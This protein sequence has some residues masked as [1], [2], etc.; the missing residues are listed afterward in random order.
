MALISICMMT[1]IFQSIACTYT[2]FRCVDKKEEENKKKLVIIALLFFLISQFFMESFKSNPEITIFS[3]HIT[4]LIL[5]SILYRKN[6]WGALT[7][8]TMTYFILGIYYVIFGNVI[9]RYVKMILPQEYINYEKIFIIYIPAWILLLIYF[10]YIRNVKQIYK[11]IV[12][13]QISILFLIMSFIIDFIL[14]SYSVELT[15]K[16]Q[17]IKNIVYMIFF[18]SFIV[19]LVYF[20]KVHQKSIQ[21]YKLNE[22]LE[23]KNN[24]LRKIKHDYGAQISY[25]YGLCL[26]KR[27]EDLKKSLKD[28]INN[29]EST[30]TAV[31]VSM[32]NKSVLS[33]ALKPAIDR[34]IHVIIEENCD[35]SFIKMNE[36]EFYRVISSIVSNAIRAMN[37]EG[38]IIA[39]SYE[40]LGHIV[41]RIENNGPKIPE[42]HLSE[43]FK[44]GFT[45]KENSD[46]NR[47][48]GLSI[49][50]DLVESY[51]GKVYVKSNESTTEFKIVLPII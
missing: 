6:I 26:M 51:N 22:A 24:E 19:T 5:L 12:Y 42:S 37:G 11:F 3:T 29:N 25:L 34:G 38:V 7:A 39:R 28:I 35:F 4:G 8:Y 43:I 46:N 36:I 10:K 50:K 2:I 21:I 41:V 15:E 31:E 27:Y 47:G 30:P 13:E 1:S 16:N 45:T 9:F 32:D 23:T 44:A 49:A 18:I 14:G 48:Y 33:L 40:Y 17:L 20:W